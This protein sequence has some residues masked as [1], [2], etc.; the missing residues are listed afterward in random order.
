MINQRI[1][2]K[3]ASKEYME[4]N[5]LNYFPDLFVEKNDIQSIREFLISNEAPLY[6]IRDG[7]RPQSPFFFFETMDQCVRYLDHFSDTVIIAVSV[8]AYKKNKIILGTI[9]ICSDGQ[10][11]LTA[12]TQ[13]DCDHRSIFVVN[14]FNLNC[15]IMDKRLDRVPEFDTI[16]QFL[17]EH[18]LIDVIVEYTIYNID[19]GIKHQ[20]I[21]IQEV[22]HY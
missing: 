10:V 12:S 9:E 3:K 15:S 2:T 14:D 11:F 8:N 19:V 16:Y 22:R 5:G 7:N 4:K 21:V 20:R 6:I 13:P 1:T 17:V 18:G